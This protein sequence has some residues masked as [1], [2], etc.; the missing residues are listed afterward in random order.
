MRGLR[1]QTERGPY[2]RGSSWCTE[3]SP[4]A[5]SS[6]ADASCHHFWPSPAR[7]GHRRVPRTPPRRNLAGLPTIL[8]RRK[9]PRW[10]PPWMHCG[11]PIRELGHALGLGGRLQPHRSCFFASCVAATGAYHAMVGSCLACSSSSI[12]SG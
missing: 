5:F 11:G 12:Y 2:P 8:P 1:G 4:S 6:S 7:P 3:I 10:R 9:S